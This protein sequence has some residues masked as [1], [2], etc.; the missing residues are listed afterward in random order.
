LKIC[1]NARADE[2][3]ETIIRLDYILNWSYMS[4]LLVLVTLLVGIAL[5]SYGIVHDFNFFT[6]YLGLG[7]ISISV[8]LRILARRKAEEL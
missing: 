3:L 8:A 2:W 7:I 6:T 4:R 5:V 1:L